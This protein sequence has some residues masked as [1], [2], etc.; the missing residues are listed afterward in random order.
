MLFYGTFLV[1]FPGSS[2]GF[3]FLI[4]DNTWASVLLSPLCR[5]CFILC[6]RT[7]ATRTSMRDFYWQLLYNFF[8]VLYSVAMAD[9]NQISQNTCVKLEAD[10]FSIKNFI[11]ISFLVKGKFLFVY[12]LLLVYNSFRCFRLQLLFY[13]TDF[14]W[15]NILRAAVV[16]GQ[17][18]R[19]TNYKFCQGFFH[20]NV[21]LLQKLPT[22]LDTFE[23]PVIFYDGSSL[24]KCKFLKFCP[25]AAMPY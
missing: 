3:V 24:Q 1:R 5:I 22:I 16:D 20:I 21:W 2:I 23:C 8:N 18:K 10:Y 11:F 17:H 15:V 7:N 6:C 13:T 19:N 12:G 4:L 14:N 25:T 9:A